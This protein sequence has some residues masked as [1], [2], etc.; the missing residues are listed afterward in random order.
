MATGKTWGDAPFQ[1]VCPDGTSHHITVSGR[2]R[3][4]LE[5]LI[6]AGTRGCTP[7]DNPAPRWSGYIH[8][9]RE[10]GVPIETYN[11]RHDGPF[12]GTHGRYVLKAQVMLLKVAA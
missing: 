12:S 2:N 9:L 10:L 1:V 7:I 3:W 6:N 4:A 8:N 11:E 5:E